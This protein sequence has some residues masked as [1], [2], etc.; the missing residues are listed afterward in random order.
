MPAI[1]FIINYDVSRSFRCRQLEAMFD[2]PPQERGHLEWKGDLPIEAM[3][4]SVGL[5]V[6]HSG[7]GKTTISTRLFGDRH[8]Q[9]LAWSGKAVIDDFG[10]QFGIEKVAQA[11]QAVGFN[12]IPAWFRPFAVLSTGEKFRV[13]MARRLL[14]GGELIIM[15]EFTSVV[16]RQVAK[17]GA[18]AVQKYVR[19]NGKKFVA[20][21]C[22][23]DVEEWLQPDWVFDVA[24]MQFR[25]RG[26]LQRRPRVEC[27][28]RRVKYDQWRIFAPYHYLT[29]EL[30]RAAAC[31]GLFVDGR[32]AAFAGVLHRPNWRKSGQNIKG[33]S[34]IVSLPDWQ[35]IG[36]SPALAASLGGAY[37]ALGWRLRAYPAHPALI[38]TAAQSPDW[39][40]IKKPGIVSKVNAGNIRERTSRAMR[41]NSRPGAVFEYCGAA[42]NRKE[43]AALI[44][45]RPLS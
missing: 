20:V 21:T 27:E 42:M 19:R 26:C 12:T 35:G 10:E 32:I 17:I 31:F 36:L 6:G 15:D 33:I 45:G 40:L 29:V 41:A 38:R 11:C 14:E 22:H 5:I 43:A 16:D 39:A 28:I 1:D 3:D 18:H 2:V 8:L 34:R 13:E 44:E 23:Y 37:K 9:A 30:H 7:S 24:V 4:W 25:P